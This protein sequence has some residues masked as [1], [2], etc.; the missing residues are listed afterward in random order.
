[1]PPHRR[2]APFH[3]RPRS[4]PARLLIR[5]PRV[6]AQMRWTLTSA[7]VVRRLTTPAWTRRMMACG[8]GVRRRRRLRRTARR[9][10]LRTARAG[11]GHLAPE[12]LLHGGTLSWSAYALPQSCCQGRPQRRTCKQYRIYVRGLR[13]VI[14]RDSMFGL[15]VTLTQAVL[16]DY[17]SFRPRAI[18][19]LTV[20]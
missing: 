9:E 5:P 8:A 14:H 10:R 2:S 1:M 17:R 3:A 4:V 16:N 20:P 12:H 13:G 11:L 18:K 6:P 7:A 15:S 19:G